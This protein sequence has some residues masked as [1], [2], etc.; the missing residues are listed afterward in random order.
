[1]HTQKNRIMSEKN[2]NKTEENFASVESALGKTEHFIENNKKFIT[3]IVGGLVAIILISV[4][5]YKYIYK[6]NQLEAYDKV[7]MAQRYF[8]LDSLDKAL[9]GDGINPGFLKIIDEYGSTKTG[10]LANFYVG[11]IYL[12]KAT[13]DTLKAKDYFQKSLDYFGDFSSDDM[14]LSATAK[15]RMGDCY[16]ELGDKEKAVE[17]YLAAAKMHEENNFIN[18]QF[19]FRAAQVYSIMEK[20][21]EALDLFKEIETKYPLSTEGREIKKYIGYEEQILEK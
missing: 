8:E 13:K 18:P 9:N 16:L 21:Q 20:H 2:L 11:S 14:N 15:G 3:Y 6:V 17:M 10:N 4:L 1:M 5:Y 19:L 7:V 12:Q